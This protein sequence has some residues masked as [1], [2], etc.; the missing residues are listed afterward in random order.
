MGGKK[1]RQQMLTLS[2]IVISTFFFVFSNKASD[3]IYISCCISS[4]TAA[5]QTCCHTIFGIPL[6]TFTTLSQCQLHD[7]SSVPGSILYYVIL[8][9]EKELCETFR[10]V[11]LEMYC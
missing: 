2:C 1:I 5:L 10:F 8:G 6:M 3:S 7:S 4:F 11:S 9:C